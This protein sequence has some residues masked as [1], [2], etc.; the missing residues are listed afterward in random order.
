MSDLNLAELLTP[1]ED[2]A[3][4]ELSEALVVDINSRVLRMIKKLRLKKVLKVFEIS[5]NGLSIKISIE[6]E[7]MSEMEERKKN[8]RQRDNTPNYMI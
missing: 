3:L 4:Q 5:I 1:E 6:D 2:L 7:Y 8:E